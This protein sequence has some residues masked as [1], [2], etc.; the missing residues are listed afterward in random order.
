MSDHYCCKRCGQEYKDCRCAGKDSRIMVLNVGSDPA[1]P[2]GTWLILVL[3]L[4][5]RYGDDAIL[6]TNAGWNNVD[7][8]IIK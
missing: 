6:N 7:L 1:M 8:E 2:L 3:L 4:I 5:E